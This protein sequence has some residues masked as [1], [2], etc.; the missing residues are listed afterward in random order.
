MP[1]SDRGGLTHDTDRELLKGLV[2]DVGYIKKAIDEIKEG[3]KNQESRIEELERW[4]CYKTGSADATD[5]PSVLKNFNERLNSLERWKAGV[6]AVA[7]AIS[8]GVSLLVKV[9]WGK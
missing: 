2:K 8:F 5:L 1:A 3:Q 7:G 4:K 9:L 6:M